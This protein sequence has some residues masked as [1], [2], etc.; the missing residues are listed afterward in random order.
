MPERRYPSD[1]RKPVA[2]FSFFAGP[3]GASI[4]ATLSVDNYDDGVVTL[5]LDMGPGG[6]SLSI[7][8]ASRDA[9]NVADLMLA[10]AS[11]AAR[12]G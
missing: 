8:I 2:V 1:K 7:D 6:D 5:L 10:Y 3:A 4:S 11:K 12:V 9:E